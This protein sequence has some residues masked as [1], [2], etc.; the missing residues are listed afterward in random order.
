MHKKVHNQEGISFA[1]S[2]KSL[3]YDLGFTCRL[4][5]QKIHCMHN[6]LCDIYS[7]KW[8]AENWVFVIVLHVSAWFYEFNG[9]EY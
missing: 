5:K 9:S 6:W 2:E 4:Q 7:E 3:E 1:D 8:L